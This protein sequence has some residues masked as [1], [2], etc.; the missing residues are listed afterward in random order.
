MMPLEA[1]QGALELLRSEDQTEAAKELIAK[2][3]TEITRSGVHDP[4]HICARAIKE[5]GIQ[6]D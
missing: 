1:Y 6:I 4:A 2:K 5:L 3:V